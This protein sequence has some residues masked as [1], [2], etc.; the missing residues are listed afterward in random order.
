MS[1]SLQ[2][3]SKSFEGFIGAFTLFTEAF[4]EEEVRRLT[5][6]YTNDATERKLFDELLTLNL[7]SVLR[8]AF[9]NLDCTAD[10]PMR[11]Y[12]STSGLL[13]LLFLFFRNGPVSARCAA[14]NLASKVVP[15]LECELVDG[16][17]QRNGLAISGTFLEYV[18]HTICGFYDFTKFESGSADVS[19]DGS[20]E[21]LQILSEAYVSLFKSLTKSNSLWHNYVESAIEKFVLD[22]KSFIS[23]LHE[24]LGSPS[25]SP[26]E[27]TAEFWSKANS[28]VGL[29]AIL[30]AFSF[31]CAM[32]STC[33]YCDPITG[34]TE[35]VIVLGSTFIPST[36]EKWTDEQK[37]LWADA[38]SSGDAIAVI[39]I[40]SN[41]G[42]F[43]DILTVHKKTLTPLMQSPLSTNYFA[44]FIS[45]RFEK[46]GLKN[47]FQAILLLE[48]S[49]S[50]DI[51]T[52]LEANVL[53]E[54]IYES[55]HPYNND[56]NDFVEISF[57][58]AYKLEIFFDERSRT[59]TNCDS[60]EFFK[61]AKKTESYG[62]K[63]SG[64]VSFD[65]SEL[66]FFSFNYRM[67]IK[68]G[69]GAKGAT[70]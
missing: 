61:D 52:V 40:S 53:E 33:L 25:S 39:P 32:G 36:D 23:S 30:G 2:S 48:V 9:D 13:D 27:V 20:G 58:G 70:L 47:F 24:I 55:V 7:L 38:K 18:L 1:N 44:D 12:I 22:A 51:P 50:R 35:Q 63:Y 69:V 42:N 37:R 66:Y 64:R 4:T 45:A 28:V 10:L 34:M 68:I 46:L 29:L 17:A 65:I 3:Q 6:I 62:P 41:G 57:D 31:S 16:V 56:S 67:A 49:D 54:A 60:V 5:E 26:S 19:F 8:N 14:I 43:E 59:E 15:Y 21:E 11:R